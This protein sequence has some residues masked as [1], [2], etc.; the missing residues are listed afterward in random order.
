M[1]QSRCCDE[2]GVHCHGS[3][4]TYLNG[5]P[6]NWRFAL[7]WRWPKAVI[8]RPAEHRFAVALNRYPGIVI[9]VVVQFGTR[10]LSIL[11]GRP[12]RIIEVSTDGR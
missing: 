5:Q 3:W 6:Y 11:W 7:E 10:G 8:V 2:R 1:T 12:G 9:G 4:Q